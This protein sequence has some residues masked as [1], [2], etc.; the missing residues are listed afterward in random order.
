MKFIAKARNGEES[1]LEEVLLTRGGLADP[2]E[3]LPSAL[4]SFPKGPPAFL[5]NATDFKQW[6]FGRHLGKPPHP[7]APSRRNPWL[8]KSPIGEGARRPGRALWACLV[9][10]LVKMCQW[11][12]P[13]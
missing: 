8:G 11:E 1:A 10:V 4:L 6:S 7:D 5:Q 3:E 12:W 9:S 13:F 2:A